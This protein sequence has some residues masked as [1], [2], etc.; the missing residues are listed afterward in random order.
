VP[1]SAKEAHRDLTVS[2]VGNGEE[3]RFDR[4]VAEQLI[5]VTVCVHPVPRCKVAATL[6]ADVEDASESGLWQTGQG[7]GVDRG[8]VAEPD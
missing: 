3:D 8:N 1:P 7:I 4:G 2:A 6:L 5:K